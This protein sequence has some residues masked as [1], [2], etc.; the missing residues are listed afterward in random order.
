MAD[1]NSTTIPPKTYVTAE[2]HHVRISNHPESATGVTPIQIITL[3]RPEKLNAIS[4]GM[5]TALISFFE[6]IDK[7][8]RVKVVIL[9]GT[10]R[11]FSAGIDLNMDNSKVK[12]SLPVSQMRDPGGTLALAMFN[13]TKP[14]IVAYNGLSVGIGMTST[15][16][17]TIR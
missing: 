1:Q 8:D 15:L 9:T 2:D 12:D 17:A 6:I 5:I 7:D 13:C 10:G 14:V 3:N 16:A 4:R 11:V